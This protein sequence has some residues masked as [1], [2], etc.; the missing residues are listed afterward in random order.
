MP[1]M[2][3]L[4]LFMIEVDSL[5]HGQNRYSGRWEDG[6]SHYRLVAIHILLGS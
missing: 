6:I 2:L 1:V 5:N 3:N 4:A